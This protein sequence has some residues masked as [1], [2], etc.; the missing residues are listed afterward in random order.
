LRYET[1][2]RDQYAGR[3]AARVAIRRECKAFEAVPSRAGV[4]DG[5]M[6][7]WDLTAERAKPEL[8][9]KLADR[10]VR[11][12]SLPPVPELPE[13]W[14]AV[15]MAWACAVREGMIVIVDMPQAQQRRWGKKIKRLARSLGKVVT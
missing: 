7:Y 11:V 3:T 14:R 10:N 12:L 4:D 13:Y 1:L 2:L 8:K 6:E 9:A 15:E 5:D